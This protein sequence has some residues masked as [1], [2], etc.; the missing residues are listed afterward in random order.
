MTP[1]FRK[2]IDKARRLTNRNFHTLAL[3]ALAEGLGT[4]TGNILADGLQQIEDAHEAHG[5]LTA[6]LRKLRDIFND[7]VL[8]QIEL[9]F[10]KYGLEQA[11]KAL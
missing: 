3:K 4:E 2:A 6:D 1:R 10:G 9:A 8:S 11:R 7:Q 5:E